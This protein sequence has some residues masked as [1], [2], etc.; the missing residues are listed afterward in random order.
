MAALDQSARADAVRPGA[1]ARA[2]G[3]SRLEMILV[4][5]FAVVVIGGWEL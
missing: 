4:P 2:R 5:L 1:P 3:R